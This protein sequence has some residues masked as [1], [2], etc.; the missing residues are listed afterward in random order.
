MQTGL[1]ALIRKDL[2]CDSDEFSNDL[3]VR[4]GFGFVQKGL[5]CGVAGVRFEPDT[6]M[7]PKVFRFVLLAF[8]VLHGLLTAGVRILDVPALQDSLGV[9][10]EGLGGGGGHL[11]AEF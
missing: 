2:A 8:I 11:Q 4:R 9:H 1:L 10:Q 3:E 5:E 7:G 6:A